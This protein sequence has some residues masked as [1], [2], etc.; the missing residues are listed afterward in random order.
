M[1]LHARPLTPDEYTSLRQLAHSRTAPARLVERARII[2]QAQ[3][4]RRVAAI[5][6]ALRLNHK[7]VRR[8]L[9]HFNEHGLAGL[10][11]QPRT[12][13]PATY[14]AEEV[15]TVIALALTDPQQLGLPFG[16]WTLDRLAAYLH[17]HQGIAIKRSRIGELLL[18]EGLRWRSQETWYGERVDPAFAEKRGPSSPFTRPHRR[19]V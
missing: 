19:V 3:Q 4:G 12:G 2:W 14:T 7:T 15:G 5:A 11:D 9:T 18:A 10:A 13:R 16:A 17:E 8:W 6:A 1:V